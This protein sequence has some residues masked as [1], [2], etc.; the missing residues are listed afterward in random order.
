[1]AKKFGDLFRV[2]SQNG[3]TE[4]KGSKSQALGP[5]LAP[6]AA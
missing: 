3:K 1:M 4:E 2:N 5:L 6:P